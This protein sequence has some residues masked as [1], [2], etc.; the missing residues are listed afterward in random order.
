MW[1]IIADGW[2]SPRI[3]HCSN[4][5]A[6]AMKSL[7]GSSAAASSVVSYRQVQAHSETCLA[8]CLGFVLRVRPTWKSLNVDRCER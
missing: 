3:A 8:H 4:A 1:S 6:L 2:H 5:Q 7:R